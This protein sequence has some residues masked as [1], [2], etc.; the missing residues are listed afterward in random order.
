MQFLPCRVEASKVVH[1]GV[2]QARCGKVS[3]PRRRRSTSADWTGGI[4]WER[5][6]AIAFRHAVV[7]AP[8]RFWWR[9]RRSVDE[10]F[11]ERSTYADKDARAARKAVNRMAL[12]GF[13]ISAWPLAAGA[14][15]EFC[16][17][18]GTR[19]CPVYAET[20]VFGSSLI[21]LPGRANAV[22]SCE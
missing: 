18:S 3:I 14:P 10:S 17:V 12:R 8:H 16:Q 15:P 5:P 2:G 1:V 21:E 7:P 22:R 13:P 4:S 20:G 9:V 6:E 19:Y 11:P